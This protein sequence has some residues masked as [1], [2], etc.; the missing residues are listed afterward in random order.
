MVTKI[1]C[2]LAALLLAVVLLTACQQPIAVAP[3]ASPV[4]PATV[5]PTAVVSPVPDIARGYQVW[6]DKKCN[7]CHG[8]Q[9]GGGIGPALAATDLLL[10][11]FEQKLRTTAPPHPGFDKAEIPMRDAGDLYAWLRGLVAVQRPA[12]EKT[13]TV[14]PE[15]C[16]ELQG[17]TLWTALRCNDCHGAFA[18][19][20]LKAPALVSL[21]DPTVVELANMRQTADNIDEHQATHIDDATFARLYKWLQSGSGLGGGACP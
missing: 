10:D 15:A 8:P 6:V 19:G 1:R 18:Q 21:N 14:P 16:A 4:K 5:S 17:M 9:A 20:S 2:V 12:G 7:A 11:E 3:P 13:P